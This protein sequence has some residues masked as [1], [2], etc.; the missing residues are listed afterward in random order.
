MSIQ[1]NDFVTQNILFSETLHVLKGHSRHVH[2]I[3]SVRSFGINYQ[4]TKWMVKAMLSIVLTDASLS[5]KN[6]GEQCQHSS[7]SL[8]NKNIFITVEANGYQAAL[9][10]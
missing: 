3:P 8:F 6:D 10:N 7:I 1:Y 9:S 5:F 4:H 2:H